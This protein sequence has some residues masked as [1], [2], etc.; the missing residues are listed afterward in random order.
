MMKN[1][2]P[3]PKNKPYNDYSSYVL[4]LFGCRVQ[5]ISIHAGF[6]CP[7]RDGTKGYGGCSYCL[8]ESFSPF[9]CHQEKPVEQQ[10]DEGIAFFA[11]KYKAMRYLVYFQTYTNTYADVEDLGILYRKMLNHDKVLGLIVATRP[12]CIDAEI[13][14]LL[15][16]LSNKHYIAIELGVESTLD[17]TLQRINRHHTYGQSADAIKLAKQFN[18]PCGIHLIMGLPGETVSDMTD[19]AV[20]IS[21]LPVSSLKIHQLQVL[22][23]TSIAREFETK[24]TDFHHFDVDDYIDLCIDML[25]KLNPAIVIERFISESPVDL[26]I[27]PRWGK[28]KNFEFVSRLEKR[29]YERK[30]YQGKLFC[31]TS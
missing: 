8:N 19:H 26:V 20:K 18:I 17:R 21:E 31:A 13:L 24:S 7:N 3:E 22:K 30:T 4:R 1:A 11:R 29:M 10:L 23:G 14:S 9:Y 6:S 16:G 27:H 2:A 15:A 25:E 5:K 12:D 28:I